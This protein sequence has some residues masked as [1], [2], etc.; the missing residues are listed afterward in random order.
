[1]YPA[2][3]FLFPPH[4][5]NDPMACLFRAFLS[6]RNIFVDEFNDIMLDA[7]PGD[8]GERKYNPT[9]KKMRN[10][11]ASYFS[12]DTLKEAEQNTPDEPEQTPKYLAMLTHPNTP[13]IV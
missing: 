2:V 11:T 9:T 1:M 10:N 7:L 6:P 4:I 3:D 8:Y 13:P 12:S 5:L